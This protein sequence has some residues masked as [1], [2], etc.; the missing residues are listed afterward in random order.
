[1]LEA[2]FLPWAHLP[3]ASPRK[4]LPPKR[5]KRKNPTMVSE[6]E[7]LIV[8]ILL[9]KEMGVRVLM[10]KSDSLLITGQ[11]TGEFQAKDP[12]MAAIWSMCRS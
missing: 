4:K 2:S 5:A 6:Y 3:V 9:A 8:G 10:A 7:A 11:V 1:M 12:Q